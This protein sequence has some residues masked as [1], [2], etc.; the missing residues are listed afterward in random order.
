MTCR[1]DRTHVGLADRRGFIAG[2]ACTTISPMAAN[3]QLAG[4]PVAK[5]LVWTSGSQHDGLID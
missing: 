4:P 5:G 2:L 3:A 1:C